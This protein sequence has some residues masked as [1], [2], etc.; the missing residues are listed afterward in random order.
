[1]QFLLDFLWL[2]LLGGMA[3][4]DRIA[5]WNFMLSQPL[6]G[7]C[8][9]GVLVHAGPDFEIWAL[10]IPIAVGAV[11]QLLLTNAALPAAQKRHDTATAGPI[12]TTVA[13][14]A[15]EHLHS[16]MPSSGGGLLWVLIGVLA[17][18]V[19]AW[20]GGAVIGLHRWAAAADTRRA[21]V[22]ASTGHVAAYEAHYL[23][24][25]LRVFFLG[26]VWTWLCA[27]VFFLLALV[28]L[29]PLAGSI[30]TPRIGFVFA[31]ML[32]AALA[33]SYETHVKG[34]KRGLLWSAAGAAAAVALILT[35]AAEPL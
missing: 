34:V 3:T 27:F 23:W 2:A 29:P 16:V 20:L 21:V 35:L 9:A 12:G 31:V 11:L 14:L 1:M 5:G 26:G 8:L 4:A 18:L 33:A 7:A 25:L 15:M 13:V 10:R 32:G 22:L 28:V 30:T 24:S 17:G 19:A 6:V